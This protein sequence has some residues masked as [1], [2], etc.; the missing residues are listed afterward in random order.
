MWP[1]T[2]DRCWDLSMAFE[3]TKGKILPELADPEERGPSS[4][5]EATVDKI[6]SH[7]PSHTYCT[8]LIYTQGKYRHLSHMTGQNSKCANQ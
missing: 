2:L 5:S 4:I 8:L 6:I 7:Q 1:L 3:A